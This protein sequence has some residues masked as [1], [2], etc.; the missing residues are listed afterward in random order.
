VHNLCQRVNT[1]LCKARKHYPLKVFGAVM[2][3]MLLHMIVISNGS[4]Y[5]IGKFDV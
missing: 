1:N 3:S 4:L 2:N 5:H